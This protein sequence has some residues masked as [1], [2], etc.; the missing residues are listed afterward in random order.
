MFEILL[1]APFPK[2]E[3][4]PGC[5]YQAMLKPGKRAVPGT[6]VQLL[7]RAEK[8]RADAPGFTVAERL[9]DGTFAVDFDTPDQEALQAEFGRIPLPPYINISTQCCCCC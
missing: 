8:L 2:G 9:E 7:D 4:V 1:I 6:R 3:T 5:R